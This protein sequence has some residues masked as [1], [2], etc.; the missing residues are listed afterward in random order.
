[1]STPDFTIGIEEEYLLVDRGQPRSGERSAAGDAERMPGAAAGP[2]EPGIPALPDR[3]RHHA[4]ARAWP[5]RAANSPIC[6][7]SVADVAGAPRPGARSP[8]RP[9]PSPNGIARRPTDRERYTLLARDLQAPA[10]RLVICGMHVHVGLGRSGAAHRSDGPDDLF[11][12]AS[13]G[14]QHLLAVLGW[15]GYRASNPIASPCSTRCRAPA[16]PSCSRAGAS[17][18]AI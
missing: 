15:R 8:P 12:A 1:M 3:G 14:A 6:A 4:S 10:R 11:P 5:R 16:C 7:R 17:S 18:S 2:G 13:A 9:I